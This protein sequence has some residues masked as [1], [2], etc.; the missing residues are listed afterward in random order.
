MGS[1]RK[2]NKLSTVTLIGSTRNKTKV[3]TVTLIGSTRNRNKT[4]NQVLF[5]LEPVR[6]E[7]G[8]TPPLPQDTST[9][10]H[11]YAN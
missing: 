11:C 8:H 2:E 1:T 6:L 5:V 9:A 10:L 3:L 7:T 4:I